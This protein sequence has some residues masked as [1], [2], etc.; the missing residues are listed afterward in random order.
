[1]LSAVLAELGYTIV[2]SIHDT[3][4]ASCLVEP[5][6]PTD[7]RAR[8]ALLADPQRDAALVHRFQLGTT[9]DRRD[10]DARRRPM[11]GEPRR[12]VSADG[13]G[14]ED[15]DAHRFMRGIPEASSPPA[16]YWMHAS[17]WAAAHDTALSLVLMVADQKNPSIV[18]E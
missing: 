3:H 5:S 18:P 6:T 17:S 9:R 1:M 10:L 15:Y 4:H 12:E 14:A 8:G 13:P 16:P 7:N 2:L 11:R